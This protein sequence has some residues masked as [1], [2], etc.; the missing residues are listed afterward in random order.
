MCHI[1]EKIR[2]FAVELRQEERA[3][4]TVENYLRHA[5]AFAAWLRGRPI[6]PELCNQWKSHLLETGYALAGP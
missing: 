4:G 3:P 1:H 2:Q 6:T 5:H